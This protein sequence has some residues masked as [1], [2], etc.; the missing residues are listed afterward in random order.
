VVL[1]GLGEPGHP[2]HRIAG[3]PDP[4]GMVDSAYLR[5]VHALRWTARCAASGV[6]VR[7]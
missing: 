4:G 5:R 1:D 6:E 7:G 3:A 2:C